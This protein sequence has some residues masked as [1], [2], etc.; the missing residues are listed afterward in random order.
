MRQLFE[1]AIQTDRSIEKQAHRAEE[2][3]QK[4]EPHFCKSELLSTIY[5]LV[6]PV[7]LEKLATASLS[8]DYNTRLNS[9]YWNIK[10]SL[11]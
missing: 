3:L 1:L 4:N 6:F 5:Q 10:C 11:N 7:T 8:N 9:P 2:G